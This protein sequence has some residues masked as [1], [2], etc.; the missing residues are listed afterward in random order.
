MSRV[1]VTGANGFIAARLIP[2]LARDHQVVALA[3]RAPTPALAPLATW[4]QAELDD[5]RTL[6]TA[7]LRDVAAVVHLAGL[8]HVDPRHDAGFAARLRAINVDLPTALAEAAARQGVQRFIFVSSAT[9]HGPDSDA[10]PFREDSPVQPAG[11]YPGSKVEAERRLA[12]LRQARDM[13][14]TIVRPPLVY[15]P[16]VKGNLARLLAWAERRRPLPTAVFRNRRSFIALENLCRFLCRLVESPAGRNEVFLVSDNQDVSTGDLYTLLSR[17]LGHDPRFLPIP[18][19]PLRV[20]LRAAGQGAAVSRLFGNCQVDPTKA[21]TT[22]DWQPRPV[23][24]D[25]IARTVQAF[26]DAA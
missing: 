17:A 12:D 21:M 26:R 9:V 3:R 14:I 11:P 10:Q 24:Q 19:G 16:G 22:L 1:L 25:E 20:A 2:E 7:V 5:P 15:G 23:M 6:P 18:F 4:H 8:A 13:D